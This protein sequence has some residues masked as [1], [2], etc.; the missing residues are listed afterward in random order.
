MAIGCNYPVQKLTVVIRGTNRDKFSGKRKKFLKQKRS[1][2]R[3]KVTEYK[4]KP[5]ID[6]TEPEQIGF[7][8]PFKKE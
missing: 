1:G 2:V 5:Q 6:V 8:Q 7:G 3:G 4:G